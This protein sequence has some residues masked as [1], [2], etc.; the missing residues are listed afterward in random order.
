[1]TADKHTDSRYLELDAVGK[2]YRRAQS[3]NS[4]TALENINLHLTQGEIFCLLGP[5]GC[6]KSTILN[7]VAGFEFPTR[8]SVLFRGSPVSGPGPERAVVFQT[9]TLF[10]WM[11]VL[12]NVTMPL[13][14]NGVAKTQRD[15]QAMAAL[16]EMDLLGCVSQHPYELSGGMNQRVDIARALIM[17]PEIILLDEPFAALDAQVREEMQNLLVRVWQQHRRTMLFITHSVE[18][19]VLLGHRIAVM[20]KNPGRITTV[21]TIDLEYPRDVTSPAFNVYR[22]EILGQI[23]QE[24]IRSRSG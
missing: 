21:T 5:S 22:R 19:A 4:V 8:G 11:T 15:Q 13:R 16:E 9:P 10:P 3:Q 14:L 24:V 20:G 23:K 7:L 6:G 17:N 1:M 12:D 2:T 18:E